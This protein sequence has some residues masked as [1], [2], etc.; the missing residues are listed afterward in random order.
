LELLTFEEVANEIAASLDILESQARDMPERQLSVRAAFDYSWQRLEP[1][2]QQAFSRLA[3]FRGGFS[4]RAAQQIAGA[5]LRTLRTL[6]EK[7]FTTAEG[8]DRYAIHELLRQF[9]EEKLETAGKAEP[10]REAHSQY[11]LAAVAER[12]AD[13]K[14]LRQLEALEEI[15]VDLDNV[16]AAWSWALEKQEEHAIDQAQEGISLFFY[17]R[18]W[19]QEGWFLF[20]QA[21]RVLAVDRTRSDY[22]RRVWGR[23]TARAG[24]LQAQFAES[25]PKI[26][27][28]IKKSLVIAETNANEAEIAYSHLALGHY[29]SRVTNDYQQA[30][31]Y[32]LRSLERYQALGDLYYVAHILHRVGYCYGF[33]TGGEDYIHFTSRS[34]ELARQIGDLSDAANALG[35]L[36]WSSLDTADYVAAESYARESIALSRQLRNFLGVAHSLILLGLCHVLFGRLEE[37]QKAATDGIVIA[38][39]LVFIN[40][41]AYGLAITSVKAS[42]QG[43]YELGRQLA[44]ES[45]ELHANPSG[46][47]LGH[48]ALA[49]AFV[50]VGE[51]EKAR[52]H[53]LA[54]FEICARWEWETRMTLLLPA[55]GINLAQQRHPERAVELLALFYYHPFSATGW[56]ENWALLSDWQTRLKE[57]LGV[58]RY[59]VAWERGRKLDLAATIGGYLDERE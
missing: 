27:E 22:S 59:Q 17:I 29:H 50:G 8:P 26:E 30:L 48:W 24:L 39:D 54:A 45:L 11:Y 25:A 3:V 52:H 31:D 15:E 47:F 21:L 5:G 57:R 18:T 1:E 35:N 36:G 43:D 13:L 58:E 7:S 4:R 37:A 10:I 56:T 55:I 28:A 6:V 46:D 38:K 41:R 40:T 53:S 9:A 23:L 20:Q 14:G 2:D 19:N 33:V 44:E 42:L 12:E 32:F 16:R 34:L 49:M 51:T